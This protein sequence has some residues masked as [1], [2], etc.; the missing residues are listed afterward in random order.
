LRDLN[1]QVYRKLWQNKVLPS[2]YDEMSLECLHGLPT[3]SL[4][5]FLLWIITCIDPL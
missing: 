2:A 5:K 3:R 4:E 1:G